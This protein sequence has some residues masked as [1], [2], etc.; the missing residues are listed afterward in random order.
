MEHRGKDHLHLDQTRKRRG[1]KTSGHVP[2]S[3]LA[4]GFHQ[5]LGIKDLGVYMIHLKIL[6]VATKTRYSEIY[7]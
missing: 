4:M 2:L 6:S 1:T 7:K 3:S 5:F